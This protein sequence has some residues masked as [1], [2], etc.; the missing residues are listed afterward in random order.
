MLLKASQSMKVE[1]ATSHVTFEELVEM[2]DRA[3]VKLEI[4]DGIPTW[5]AFPGI[6]HQKTIFRIQT[7]LERLPD[8]NCGAFKYLTPIS[9]SLTARLSVLTCR[10]FATS[11]PTSTK[12]IHKFQKPSWKF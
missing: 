10:F 3:G 7:S 11:R 5:E 4:T 9:N 8:S 12:R 6:R 1:T 2:A